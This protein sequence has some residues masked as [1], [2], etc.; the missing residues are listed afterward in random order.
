MV[1]G[2]S[3]GGSLSEFTVATGA[4]P[5]HAVRGTVRARPTAAVLKKAVVAIRAARFFIYASAL[6]IHGNTVPDRR[7]GDADARP[8]AC[9]REDSS[10]EVPAGQF[11]LLRAVLLR[12]RVSA[13]DWGRGVAWP[14]NRD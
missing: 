8:G 14:M 9:L 3:L 13:N 1:G 6:L 7:P 12:R 11:A 10:N 5:E 4:G 2:F